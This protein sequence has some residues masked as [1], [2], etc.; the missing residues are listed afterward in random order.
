MLARMDEKA[1]RLIAVHHVI[2]QR[3]GRK[4][5]WRKWRQLADEARRGRVDDDVELPAAKTG[6]VAT[7]DRPAACEPAFEHERFLDRA[8][9]N[10]DR[11]GPFAQ[12]RQHDAARRA[13]RAHHQHALAAERKAEPVLNVPDQ[14]CA[15]G[16]V[17]KDT[18]AV[19]LER[20][21]RAR[22]VGSLGALGRKREGFELEG[23]RHVQALAARR[24]KR[25][26]GRSK[27]VV[28]RQDCFVTQVLIDLSRERGV[29]LRRFRLRDRV[30][31]HRVEIGHGVM[32]SSPPAS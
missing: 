29:D 3:S 30:A 2:R 21:D 27:T 23:H 24:A 13:A 20:I 19:E 22:L 5:A 9:G 25:C 10:G 32:F 26:D 14:A 7:L 15:I 6:I 18:L 17:A 28:R 31:D 8:I 16:V 11:R 4:H 12:K 1:R